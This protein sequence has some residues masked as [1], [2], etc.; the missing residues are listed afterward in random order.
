MGKSIT[1]SC[2]P[3]EISQVSYDKTKQQLP[4]IFPKCSVPPDIGGPHM[5]TSGKTHRKFTNIISINQEFAIK[6][7]K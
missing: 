3:N 1:S 7:C 6:N 4:F 2:T 5:D